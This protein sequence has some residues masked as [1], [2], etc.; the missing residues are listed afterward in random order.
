MKRSE[1]HRK[2][3][4]SAAV[5]VTALGFASGDAEAGW[6][7]IDD[8]NLTDTAT[9]P[10]YPSNQNAAAVGAYLQDLLNLQS[11]PTPLGQI[12]NVNGN[13]LSGLGNPAAPNYS[14][15]AFHLG[16]GNNSYPHSGPYEVFYSC[17]TACDNFTL[18][19]TQAIGN[20]RAYSAPLAS[21]A[22]LSPTEQAPGI[23]IPEPSTLALLGGGL[24]ALFLPAW[25]IARLGVRRVVH[26]TRGRHG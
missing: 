11:A 25:L 1:S 24:L 6:V 2:I 17:A 14:L 10:G 5:L 21:T 23:S 8:H 22:A 18:P 13:V 16:N 20:Y 3:I 19:G 12:G 7:F 26:S 4:H 9:N 15:L